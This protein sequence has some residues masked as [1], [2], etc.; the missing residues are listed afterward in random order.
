M[1]IAVAVNGKGKIFGGHF[2]SAPKYLIF[3]NSGKF[4]NEIENSHDPKKTKVH[5][6]NPKLIKELLNDISVF[7]GKHFG[8]KSK[9]KLINKLR[10]TPFDTKFTEPEKA[11]EE[12]L[13][14][15]G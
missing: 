1:K 5:H 3:N 12:Y 14:G 15:N 7:I 10:I 8:E 11:I 6:D 4:L 13:N 9:E 2:G